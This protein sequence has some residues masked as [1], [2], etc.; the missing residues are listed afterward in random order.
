MTEQGASP[1]LVLELTNDPLA[2]GGAMALAGI[3]R[4]PFVLLGGA[5]TDR[6]APR[7]VMPVSD[8]LRFAQA[9]LLA[10][11]VASEGRRAEVW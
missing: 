3:P 2:L 1:W 6:Y 5:V 7:A 4:A 11:L 10:G 8:G 9:C